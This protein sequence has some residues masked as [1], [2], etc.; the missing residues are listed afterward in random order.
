MDSIGIDMNDGPW[1]VVHLKTSFSKA[2][3]AGSFT[4]SEGSVR[5]KAERV[6]GYISGRRLGACPLAIVM[7][8]AALRV[9]EVPAGSDA[10]LQS[11]VGFEI[12]RHLPRAEDAAY[13]WRVT[14]RKKGVFSVLI[15][16]ARKSAV[17]DAVSVFREAGCGEVSVL[18]RASALSAALKAHGESEAKAC[19]VSGGESAHIDFFEGGFPCASVSVRNG[20]GLAG[21]IEAAITNR[22]R[23][24]LKGRATESLLLSGVADIPS[25]DLPVRTIAGKAETPRLVA[26][27]AALSV[28]KDGRALFFKRHDSRLSG[29][30]AGRLGYAAAFLLA[31]SV[32]SVPL[33]DRFDLWRVGRLVS[34][35]SAEKQAQKAGLTQLKEMESAVSALERIKGST[36]AQLELLKGLTE[37]AP[38]ETHITALDA[39]AGGEIF[40]EGLSRDA[41]AFFLK[42]EGSGFVEGL[43][44][45][46]PVTRSEGMERFRMKAKS[47]PYRNV[48]AK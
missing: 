29:P 5:E 26:Y 24:N 12:E 8:A 48:K 1:E 15:A 41:S 43:E 40:I 13:C 14:E 44:F 45:T 25:L 4:V 47:V 37:A 9:I 30:G 35:L 27:G 42:L 34:A 6:R 22:S 7:H 16:V 32:I 23:N 46:G 18:P 38:L 2:R 33:K 19:V 39:R 11:A 20:T 17:E 10:A 31:L 36:L 21:A 28:L 3:V